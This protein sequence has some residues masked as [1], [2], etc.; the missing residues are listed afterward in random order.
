M[1]F[2]LKDKKKIDYDSNKN[3]FLIGKI[4]GQGC[5]TFAAVE[6]SC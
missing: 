4:P 5:F 3:H 6:T 2:L 1:L